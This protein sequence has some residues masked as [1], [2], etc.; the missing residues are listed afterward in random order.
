[1]EAKATR[2][3]P[4]L[5]EDLSVLFF[6]N[7]P[8]G[9]ILPA[10]DQQFFATLYWFRNDGLTRQKRRLQEKFGYDRRSGQLVAYEDSE[11]FTGR[12]CRVCVEGDVFGN[13]T[14]ARKTIALGG[15]ITM[16]WLVVAGSG[17]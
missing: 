1:M 8:D 9:R 13:W 17:T 3:N 5:L 2:S 16:R 12:D 6:H 7:G 11:F 14:T 15:V 10:A 4:G